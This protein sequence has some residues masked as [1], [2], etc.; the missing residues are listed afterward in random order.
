[1]LKF[2]GPRQDSAA[3]ATAASPG[4]PGAVG[5][6]GPSGAD[7]GGVVDIK[8]RNKHRHQRV[9][10]AGAVT[11]AVGI[12]VEQQRMAQGPTDAMAGYVSGQPP[13]V[14]TVNG[15][16]L[17]DLHYIFFFVPN[18]QIDEARKRLEHQAVPVT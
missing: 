17:T 6:A 18:R 11:G 8:D 16:N 9:P 10:G 13:V 2:G 3:A 4:G 1:M 12:D 7:G 14:G 5:G 15:T